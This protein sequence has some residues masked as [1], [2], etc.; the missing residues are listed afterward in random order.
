MTLLVKDA[1]TTVQSLSTQSDAQGNLV[2]V[3][4]PAAVAGGVATPV[5]AVAPLP[6]INAAGAPAIEP[7]L[8]ALAAVEA[9]L[10]TAGDAQLRFHSGPA[11]RVPA[12]AA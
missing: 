3:H 5:S 9:E 8:A 2:P 6:V 1:N 10:V 11:L 7:R 12:P 4:V